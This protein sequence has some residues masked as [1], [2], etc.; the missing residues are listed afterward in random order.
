MTIVYCL[1]LFLYSDGFHVSESTEVSC[2]RFYFVCLNLALEIATTLNSSRVI[3]VAPPGISSIQVYSILKKDL[4]KCLV[5]VVK[6]VE[7]SGQI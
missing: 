1:W 7:K 5:E 4:A 3:S 6:I 2:H